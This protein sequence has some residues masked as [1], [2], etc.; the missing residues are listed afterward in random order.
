MKKTTVD[1]TYA[2]IFEAINKYEAQL[3]AIAECHREGNLLGV[4]AELRFYFPGFGRG[5][6][7]AEPIESMA[8][9]V[10]K[11]GGCTSE[12]FVDIFV[13]VVDA[14]EISNC[15]EIFELTDSEMKKREESVWR[16][17]VVPYAEKTVEKLKKAAQSHGANLE[18][19]T[20]YTV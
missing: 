6:R 19:F 11:P 4:R 10:V 3:M 15:Y 17:F 12:D 8:Y 18:G 9:S 13:N 7:G 16:E 5:M 20:Y 2:E 14:P 1:V